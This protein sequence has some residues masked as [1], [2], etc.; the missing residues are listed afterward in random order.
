MKPHFIRFAAAFSLLTATPALADQFEIRITNLTHG[1][2]FTPLLVVAHS[3]KGD[4]FTAG[5]KA[6]EPLE[7][8]AEAGDV[9]DLKALSESLG[10][11]TAVA[12]DTPLGPGRTAIVK[13]DT[14]DQ[15]LLSIVGMILPTNDGLVGLD[16]F[17]LRSVGRREVLFLGSYDA[18]TEINDELLV[19]GAGFN[20]PGIPG[21]PGGNSGSGGTGS[22]A[23]EPNTR[24][25]THPGIVGDTDPTGGPSDLDP[26]VHR[27]QD[28]V[29]RVVI[30][31]RP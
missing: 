28:P 8:V 2:W 1:S 12:N 9:T 18:G 5:R 20:V 3:A 14:G 23:I 24:I 11:K 7:K 30:L 16:A 13:L 6:S 21:D 31:R 10:G 15:P 4:L 22:T 19:P 27:W 26:A 25:H 17:R 29:A